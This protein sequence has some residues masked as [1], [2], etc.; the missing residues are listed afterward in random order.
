MDTSIDEFKDTRSR[1]DP[2]EDL[3]GDLSLDEDDLV[4]PHP[5]VDD[6]HPY[7]IDP[8]PPLAPP[9]PPI[10]YLHP[11]PVHNPHAAIMAEGGDPMAAFKTAI[12]EAF[13]AANRNSTYPMPTFAGKKGDKPEDH[14]L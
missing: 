3:H 7:P 1:L 6:L 4:I 8:V 11:V 2:M 10:P 14:T 9:P 5:V 12:I 13:Q